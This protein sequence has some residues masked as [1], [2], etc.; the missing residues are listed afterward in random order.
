[1]RVAPG[2]KLI[3]QAHQIRHQNPATIFGNIRIRINGQNIVSFQVVN[4][5]SSPDHRCCKYSEE[6][7]EKAEEEAKEVVVKEEEAEQV[8]TWV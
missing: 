5:N 7:G 3:R 2:A 8:E 6:D 4:C 1:M